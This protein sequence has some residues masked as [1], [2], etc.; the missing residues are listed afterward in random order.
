MHFQQKDLDQQFK[1][2]GKGEGKSSLFSVWCP[3]SLVTRSVHL[4][5]R[6]WHRIRAKFIVELIQDNTSVFSQMG[7][8]NLHADG[9]ISSVKAE[10][11][12]PH[13]WH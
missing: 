8:V 6:N 3:C 2:K 7:E 1:E 4:L 11:E 10:S 9:S 12:Q 13:K 5:N